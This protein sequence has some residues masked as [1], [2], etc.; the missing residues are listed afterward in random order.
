M[1]KAIKKEEVAEK[2]CVFEVSFDK[3]GQPSGV[4]QKING[5]N[6]LDVANIVMNI[7]KHLEIEPLILMGMLEAR[8]VM[9]KKSK[10]IKK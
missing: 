5:I 9:Q 6:S 10:K 4:K 2:M 7:I 3:K 8:K 1:K